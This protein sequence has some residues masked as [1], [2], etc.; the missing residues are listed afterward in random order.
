VKVIQPEQLQ[1][2]LCSALAAA[3]TPDDIAQVVA[4]S[5]VDANLKGVD[6]HGAV[7]IPSYLAY[8]AEGYVKPAER[9]ELTHETPT[10]AIVRGHYGFG[11]HTLLYATDIAIQKAKQQNVACVGLIEAT[12][13]GRV[14]WFAERAAEQNII[15]LITGGGTVRKE[16]HQSVAPYGGAQHILS[17]NP[18]TVGMPG[19][20]MG[21]VLADFATSITSE[22]KLRIYRA[23]HA[24]VPQGWLL[25]KHGNP[26]TD[27]EEFYDGGA[28]LPAGAHKGYALS[29][30]AELLGDALLGP[31]HEFNWVVIAVNIEAFRPADEFS[32]ASEEIL[33]K[34][35]RVTPAAGVSEV[36]FPG[37]PEKLAAQSR[38]KGIPIHD[39]VWQQI[40]DAVRKVGV[41]PEGLIG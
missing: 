14:G 32:H 2:L 31:A 11:I 24:P 18:L 26:T 20:S 4:A 12:H 28:I 30:V 36:L 38:A 37:E 22:G 19:G 8:I 40:A 23:R 13:T 33:S 25:D 1:S 3:G 39:E 27:A 6:S 10:T 29:V 16:R 9:P 21:T 17:T 35:K 41:N 34:I 7:R 5:L 15:A